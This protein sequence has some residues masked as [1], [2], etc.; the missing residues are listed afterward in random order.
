MN[1]DDIIQ[2][3]ITKHGHI[4]GWYKTKS[5]PQPRQNRYSRF[6]TSKTAERCKEYNAWAGAFKDALTIAMK[7][8]GIEPLGRVSLCSKYKFT[9]DRIFFEVWE[10][11][12]G[13]ANHKSD[14]SNHL[15][16]VEDVFNKVLWADD[17]WVDYIDAVRL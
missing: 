11:E 6:G 3:W 9:K 12:R 4:M 5:H 8:K 2:V 17:C 15:K 7:Q 13:T 10:N 16:A 14:L 1:L